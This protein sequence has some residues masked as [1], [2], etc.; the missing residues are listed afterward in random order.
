M[1]FDPNPQNELN[2]GETPFAF[3]MMEHMPHLKTSIGWQQYRASNTLMRGGINDYRRGINY[4]AKKFNTKAL[5]IRGREIIGSK[6]INISAGRI[7]RGPG[8]LGGFTSSNELIT[9][10]KSAFY[11]SRGTRAAKAE[12]AAQGSRAAQA[13]KAATVEAE[14]ATKAGGILGKAKG[15]VSGSHEGMMPW[16]K[17]ARA[18]HWTLNPKALTRNR[19]LAGF[20]AAENPRFYSTFHFS[21]NM[22]GGQAVKNKAFREAVYGPGAT[23]ES[24]GKEN[25]FQRG[26]LSMMTTGRRLDVLE[27]KAIKG[28]ARSLRKLGKAQNQIKNLA[29]MNNP[30]EVVRGATNLESGA[31]IRGAL[32]LNADVGGRRIIGMSGMTAPQRLAFGRAAAPEIS[33]SI[34]Y[35]GLGASGVD[36]ALAGEARVGLSGNLMASAGATTGSRF[37]QGYVRGAL[38]NINAGGLTDDAMRGATKAV[39]HMEKAIF[40]GIGSPSMNLGGK[41]LEEGVFKTLGT[42]GT[43]KALATKEG[44]TVLGARTAAMA[45]PGLNLLAT[46]SLVYDLGKMGGEVIKSGVNLAKDAVKS[47]KGSI[48]KPMFGMGYKDNEVAATSRARGVAAIQNSRLNARSALGSEGAMMAAH[49]G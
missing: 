24:I 29:N 36:K 38:G 10:S 7:G 14:T 47:M 48:D 25:V 15:A 42:K 41:A 23:V 31:A 30:L 40:K 1:A 32:S 21:R 17:G 11:G 16:A 3:R 4:S 35:K 39:T 28:S 33:T 44:A 13:A 46:A 2:G 26:M 37:T 20:E 6:E 45:I 27:G 34:S 12:R 5:N 18:E 49:F 19:T 22:I 9:P 43:F 8:K